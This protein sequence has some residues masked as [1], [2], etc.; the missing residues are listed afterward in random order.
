[1]PRNFYFGKLADI[2]AGSA[3][4]AAQI[5]ASPTSFGLVAAQATAY[6]TLNTSLQSCY[7]ASTNVS[8][9][10][11]GTVA[12]TQQA[13][14]AMR[15]EAILLSKIIYATPTVTDAQLINLGLLPRPTFAPVP[16]PT[17]SPALTVTAT[18]G[19][20]VDFK[21]QRVDALKGKAPGAKA[22]NIYSFIG[23]A[24]PT[25]I[26][27][28]KFEGMTTRNISRL[29]FPATVATGVTV[30]L[31]A[32]WVSERGYTGPAC[33]PISFILPGGVGGATKVA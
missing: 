20:I 30:W 16:A 29:E 18:S 14:K 28:F 24:P 19:R 12:A 22:A 5:S 8:T 6:G 1:M 25:D 4:Y 32:C 9:R 10:T 17:Q 21:L 31:T 27:L 13:V 7:A 23:A 2:V 15:A 26:E 11:R 3:S 33:A